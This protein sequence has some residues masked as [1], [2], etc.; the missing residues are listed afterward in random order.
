[1]GWC[2][3]TILFDS[4]LDYVL[5]DGKDADPKELIKYLINTLEDM[6]WDCQTDSDYFNHPLVR[7][8]FIELDPIWDECYKEGESE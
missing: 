3:G 6:D 4:V 2:S 5:G 7:E 1:M 8:C